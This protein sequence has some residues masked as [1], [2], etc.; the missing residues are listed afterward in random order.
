[1]SGGT[2]VLANRPE[3]IHPAPFGH[4]RIAR[5]DLSLLY[6]DVVFERETVETTRKTRAIF[7]RDSSLLIFLLNADITLDID[8]FESTNRSEGNLLLAN[9][10]SPLKNASLSA[11]RVLLVQLRRI[12]GFVSF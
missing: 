9:F 6:G 12:G 7:I 10:G 2:R 3:F 5:G 1:M 4:R 8:Q 11:K